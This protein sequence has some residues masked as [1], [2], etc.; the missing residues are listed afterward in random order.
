MKPIEDRAYKYTKNRTVDEVIERLRGSILQQEASLRDTF[1]AFNKQ[2]SAKLSK[3][4]FRKVILIVFSP[5][6]A[7]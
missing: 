2:V 6:R 4:D 7:Q 1:L 3:T 5:Y